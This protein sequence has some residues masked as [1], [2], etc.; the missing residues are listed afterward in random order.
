MDPIPSSTLTSTNSPSAQADKVASP[1]TGT[2]PT[3]STTLLE[4]QEQATSGGNHLAYCFLT[5]GNP[6]HSDHWRTFLQGTT[7][8]HIHAKHPLQIADH[9]SP[10]L[11]DEADHLPTKWG[12]ISVLRAILKLL[13]RAFRNPETEKSVI[14]SGNC[15]PFWSRTHIEATAL[16]DHRSWIPDPS[17]KSHSRK[18]NATADFVWEKGPTWTILSRADWLALSA[19]DETHHFERVFVPDEHYIPI[20]MGK[21]GRLG[22]CHRRFTTWTSWAKGARH[23][24]SLL[25]SPLSVGECLFF[26]KCF[27]HTHLRPDLIERITST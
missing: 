13:A 19:Q 12:H 5:L 17:K 8:I 16:R 15:L 2:T 26:R 20:M 23:P 18:R 7:N 6:C 4:T 21:L 14:L 24:R 10:Y 27:D 9:L 22:T 1:S 25:K 11:L 3:S